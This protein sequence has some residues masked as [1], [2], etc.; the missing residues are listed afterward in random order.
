MRSNQDPIDR[1]LCAPLFPRPLLIAI[2]N[3]SVVNSYIGTVCMYVCTTMY[4]CVV[5]TFSRVSINRVRLPISCSWS[6]EQGKL[7]LPY[8]CSRLRI[9]SRETGLAVPSRVS[10][11]IV[12]TQAE[13]AAFSRESSR[14][15]QRCPFIYTVNRHRA[16]SEFFW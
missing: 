7:M 6:A 14:F 10:L 2:V 12:Y 11:L 3:T 9:W 5:I 8:P 4:V 15:R 13:F 1:F 16:S